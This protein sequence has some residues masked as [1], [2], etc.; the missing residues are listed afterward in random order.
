MK[1]M[2]P[3][4]NVVS[5]STGFQ[6]VRSCCSSVSN[7]VCQKSF[8]AELL[9]CGIIACLYQLLVPA[10]LLIVKLI[11]VVLVNMISEYF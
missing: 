8:L 7:Q 9:D 11:C 1:C 4:I 5:E 3:L 2:D 6:I 10:V